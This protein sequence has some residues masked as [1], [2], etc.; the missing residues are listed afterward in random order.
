VQAE[1]NAELRAGRPR[2]LFSATLLQTPGAAYG[3]HYG[4]GDIVSANY[5]ATQF[6]C[7]L[8]SIHITVADGRETIQ[9]ALRADELI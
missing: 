2:R 7:R 8:D 9:A 6:N 1:A 5:I 4:L 3:I